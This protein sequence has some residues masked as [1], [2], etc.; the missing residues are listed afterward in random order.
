MELNLKP[1]SSMDSNKFR[2]LP[3]NDIVIVEVLGLQEKDARWANDD[4]SYDKQVEFSFKITDSRYEGGDW[5]RRLWGNTPTTFSMDTRCKLRAWVEAILAVDRLDESYMQ[6]PLETDALVGRSVK[7]VVSLSKNGK[8]Y[9][10][11]LIADHSNSV[12]AQ[13]AA[14]APDAFVSSDPF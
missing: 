4:G 7:A 11:D 6:K 2:A 3:A 13:A 10:S 1:A 5:S 12:A 9:V 8:N 14:P